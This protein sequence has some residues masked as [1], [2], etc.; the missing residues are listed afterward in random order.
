VETPPPQPAQTRP[1]ALIGIDVG[2]TKIAAGLIDPASGQVL[3]RR[4]IATRA[5][6]GGAEVL[7][8][9]VALAAALADDAEGLGRQVAGVGVGVCELVDPSGN[10]TS[11]ATVKWRGLPVRATLAQ[12]APAVVESDVRAHALAESRYGSGRHYRLFVFVTVGTGISSCL[13][14]DGVPLA[15]ARGNALV[16]ASSPISF[17]CASCGALQR[18]ILEEY[19]S[20]PALVER[21]NQRAAAPVE[22]AEEVVA[23]A[24]RGDESA[25]AIL[26]TAGAALGVSIA[27]LVNVLDPEAVIV[28][29]GLGSAG[30]RYWDSMLGAIRE[31]IWA[32]ASRDLP[33]LAATLG[34]DAGMIG[35]ACAAGG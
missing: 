3:A 32:D 17:I 31:H 35:A 20:G 18:P 5:E 23:A 28:G 15:G 10:V 1:A 4:R 6:R 25:Q 27:W 16:L 8:D 24:D 26:R 9:T 22:R 12:L 34:P 11:D 30:G 19:A 29:G 13:V 21:Y 2:G 33:V 7:R 14:Q